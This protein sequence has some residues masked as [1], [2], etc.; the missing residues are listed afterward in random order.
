VP[1]RETLGATLIDLQ[2]QRQQ[3]LPLGSTSARECQ[4]WWLFPKSP[5]AF[6]SGPRGADDF[7]VMIPLFVLLNK[8]ADIH[9]VA[10]L[11]D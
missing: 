11:D 8:R 2:F 1:Q 5:S 6:S 10:I 9:R 3:R 4:A 7:A